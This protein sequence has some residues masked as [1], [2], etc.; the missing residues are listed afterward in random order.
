MLEEGEASAETMRLRT[1][2]MAMMGHIEVRLDTSFAVSFGDHSLLIL[3]SLQNVM[4][5]SKQCRR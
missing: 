3:F 1:D 5:V 4:K 2:L